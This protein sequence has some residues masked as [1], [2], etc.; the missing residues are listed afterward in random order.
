M[1]SSRHSC[2]SG[3]FSFRSHLW[4]TSF[5]N[6]FTVDLNL[7]V[8]GFHHCM[9]GSNRKKFTKLM[10][11][12]RELSLLAVTCNNKHGHLPWGRSSNNKWATAE[13][14]AY[15]WPLCKAWAEVV[16]DL[17]IARGALPMPRCLK[18]CV[19][20]GANA[21]VRQARAAAGLQ[22]KSNILAPLIQSSV[23]SWCY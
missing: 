23:K 22:P 11:N 7:R 6:K 20:S 12:F 13:E 14:C 1:L 21:H 4:D 17:F 3:E 15:P 18:E 19:V 2:F 8:V 16:T 9:F 10:C 5:W